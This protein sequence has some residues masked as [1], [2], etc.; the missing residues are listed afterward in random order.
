VELALLFAGVPRRERAA[1]ARATLERVGLAERLRHRPAD[2]SGG[3]QQRVAL[4]RALVKRPA[5][6]L[7]DEP[8]GNLDRDNAHRIAGFLAE[9][10]REGITVVLV[11]HDAGL[12]AGDVH[13]TIR[14]HYGRVEGAP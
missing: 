7:A 12:A 1:R 11:T 2:L 3:E 4:A 6:L 5:L 10:C 13:R 8:T 14:M 9:L